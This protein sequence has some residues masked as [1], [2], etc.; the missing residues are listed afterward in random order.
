VA[1]AL[2]DALTDAVADA[3]DFGL[4]FVRNNKTFAVFL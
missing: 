1:S 2:I 3:E 4:G